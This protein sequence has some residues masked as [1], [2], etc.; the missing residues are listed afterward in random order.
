MSRRRARR[1][2]LLSIAVALVAAVGLSCADKLADVPTSSAAPPATAQARFMDQAALSRVAASAARA[3]AAPTESNAVAGRPGTE[4][5]EQA[6]TPA[7]PTQQPLPGTML[8]RTGQA[9]VQVDS[10]EVGLERIREMARRTG[11]VI[12]NTSM[13]DGRDRVRAASL[14]LRI[15]SDRFDDAVNGLSP[16]GK[17]ESVNVSVEDVGEEFVDVT[18]RMVNARRLE[19]RLIELLANRTGK[20]AD[21]LRVEHELARVRQEI[22]RYEGRLRY[23]RARSSVSTLTI[24]VHEPYPIVASHPGERP[25]R[26]AFVQAWRNFV[27]FS[28]SVIASLGVILPLG[29][30]VALVVLLGRRIIP[31]RVLRLPAEKPAD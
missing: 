14:E 13:Q 2:L 7:F 30:I 20:L 11:A 10:L 27:G 3:D 24:G 12:A 22:E 25:I 17:L 23:L 31:S 8:V 1:A 5:P 29:I 4:A 6:P 16:I 18:A 28:A 15:P 9:S 21:V 19:Q 26:D